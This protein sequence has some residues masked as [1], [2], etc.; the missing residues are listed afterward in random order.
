MAAVNHLAGEAPQQDQAGRAPHGAQHQVCMVST[1]PA[2]GSPLQEFISISCT[3]LHA[4][5]SPG[6][7]GVLGSPCVHPSVLETDGIFI[8]RKCQA[9]AL[10]IPA[11]LR[12]QFPHG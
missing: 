2:P 3:P 10:P 4:L 11:P 6:A 8:I 9:L 5:H 7:V 12:P 1:P